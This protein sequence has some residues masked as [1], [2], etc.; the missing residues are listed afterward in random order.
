MNLS[1]SYNMY[2]IGSSLFLREVFLRLSLCGM[3]PE[4]RSPSLGPDSS[5]AFTMKLPYVLMIP[6]PSADLTFLNFLSNPIGLGSLLE[7]EGFWLNYPRTV[8]FLFLALGGDQN[9]GTRFAFTVPA[10]RCRGWCMQMIALCFSSPTSSETLS[11]QT[12]T[13]YQAG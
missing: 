1:M 10:V 3:C 7:L 12:W 11:P 6:F 13:F 9:I 2:C 4:Y 8:L 5:P